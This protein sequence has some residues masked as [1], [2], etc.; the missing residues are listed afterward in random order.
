MRKW[1]LMI[2]A[3]AT[4]GMLWSSTHADEPGS[5]ASETDKAEPQKEQ[6]GDEKKKEEKKDFPDFKEVVTDEFKAVGI[7]FNPDG[8]KNAFYKLF[9]NKKT[10][11]L[12]AVVS[13]LKT[14]FMISSSIHAAPGIAGWMWGDRVVRWERRDKKLLLIEPDLRNEGKKGTELSDAVRRTYTDRIIKTIDIKTMDKDGPVIDLG[15]LFKEDFGQIGRV[16]RG[17]LDASL[18]KWIKIKPFEQNLILTVESP[19]KGSG[20]TFLGGRASEGTLIAVNYNISGM[21]VTDYKPRMADDRIGYFTTVR[22]DWS[23]DYKEKTLFNRYINRWHLEKQDPALEKSPVKNPIVFYIEKTVPIRFRNSVKEGILEWNKAFEQ[24][25]FLD[26]VQVYQQTDK[27]EHRYKDPEDVNYNFFRW[28]ASGVGIAVGPSRANPLTGQIYDADIVF[29]DGWIR[30]PTE[31]HAVFGPKGVASLMNDPK[32]SAFL[33]AHPRFDFTSRQE[34]L[35][36]G[37]GKDVTATQELK[38][39][40]ST[41][42]DRY[43]RQMCDYGASTQH[44]LVMADTYFAGLGYD[45]I[46]DEF[47]QQIVKEVVMHEVG[48]TIGMRHNFKASTWLPLEDVLKKTSETRPISASVMDYNAFMFN[49]KKELQGDQFDRN[50][51]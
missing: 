26:A 34:R 30:G 3:L 41:L 32:L 8:D 12:L 40:Y 38:P 43:S 47:L 16:F 1:T 31:T 33:K 7:A 6:A 42:A 23:K 15:D 24:C 45:D 9:H 36:P 11:Q 39:D 20:S 22:R 46:P 17:S 28:T 48:H 4:I 21:P 13:P 29:D 37:Y 50:P 27:N 2:F 44:E 19:Y 25:G 18:A 51:P 35:L 49:A 10:D 14:N 5:I